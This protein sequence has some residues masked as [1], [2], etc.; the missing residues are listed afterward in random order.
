[1]SAPSYLKIEN[2]CVGA[3]EHTRMFRQAI[4]HCRH[5]TTLKGVLAKVNLKEFSSCST[6]E[7]VFTKVEQICAPV[8]GIGTLSMYDISTD[9][10][11]MYGLQPSLIYCIGSG[12]RQALKILNIHPSTKMLGSLSVQATTINDIQEAF[13]KKEWSIPESVQNSTNPDD[14]ETFLCCWQKQIKSDSATGF[15]TLP[16]YKCRGT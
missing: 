8:Y 1:M 5:K 3:R 10:A 13:K 7:D 9:I 2:H 15:H 16:H 4:S 12:P 11:R 14:W 6:F